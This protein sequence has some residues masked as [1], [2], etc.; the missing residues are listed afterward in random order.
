MTYVEQGWCKKIFGQTI[1]GAETEVRM[2]AALQLCEA[3]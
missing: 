1:L 3:A 2:V